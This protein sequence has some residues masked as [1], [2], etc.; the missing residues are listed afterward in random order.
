METKSKIKVGTADIHVSGFIS[1]EPVFSHESYGESFYSFDLESKRESGTV[2]VLHC[3]VSQSI[4]DTIHANK[5]FTIDGEVRT[6]NTSDERGSHLHVSVFVETAT[7][8]MAEFMDENEV[9]I[10]CGFIAKQIATRETPLGRQITD[11]IIAVN[12]RIGTYH[13]ADYIPTITWGRLAKIF[14]RKS[15]V[16]YE[17]SIRGRLQSRPFVNKEGVANTAVELSVATMELREPEII[18]KGEK[19]DESKD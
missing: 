8:D 4:K 2:D 19:P 15:F 3:I 13:K 7:E 10:N 17:V 9:T 14:K 12:R 6:Y 16:G 18:E 5:H 11:L 1:D